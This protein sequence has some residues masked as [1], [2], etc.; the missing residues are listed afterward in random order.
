MSIALVTSEPAGIS[1]VDA[2]GADGDDR[3]VAAASND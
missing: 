3:L 1:K 2:S